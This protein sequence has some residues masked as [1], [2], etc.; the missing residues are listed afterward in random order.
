[1]VTAAERRKNPAYRATAPDPA[2]YSL[3]QKVLPGAG[4]QLA[5]TAAEKKQ[6]RAPKMAPP[7]GAGKQ[8]VVTAA[9]KRKARAGRPSQP[10]VIGAV[11]P[12]RVL[13]GAGKQLVVAAADK[14]KRLGLDANKPDFAIRSWGICAGLT[15]EAAVS[16]SVGT[17]LVTDGH[18]LALTDSSR[19]GA[20]AGA[21]GRAS[22]TGQ[23]S[24]AGV[25]DLEGYS[26]NVE[27]TAAFGGGV[28]GSAG[29][30]LDGKHN[31]T[32]SGGVV[33]GGDFSGGVNGEYTHVHRLVDLDTIWR[34]LT[35]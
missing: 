16:G 26:A 12:A 23:I 32:F 33:A 34:F 11:R 4:K 1:V 2:R 27:G 9:E 30:S 29:Q 35:P 10:G 5:V 28:T 6:V 14:R 21:G 25:D 15:A 8:L 20:A 19:V 7:P 13:P 24:T 18:V 22:I 3:P 17:C 31:K